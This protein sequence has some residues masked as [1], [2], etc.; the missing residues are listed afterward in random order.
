MHWQPSQE[1]FHLSTSSAEPDAATIIASLAIIGHQLHRNADHAKSL[2]CQHLTEV[3]QGIVHLHITRTAHPTPAPCFV[4]RISMPVHFCEFTYGTLYIVVAS[5]KATFSADAACHLAESCAMLLYTCEM[6][7]LLQQVY[8]HLCSHT[9]AKL[10]PREQDI[11]L[12]LC[13]NKTKDEIATTLSIAPRTLDK[14]KQH[15][16]DK[17]GVHNELAVLLAA[18]TRNLFFPLDKGDE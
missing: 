10:S 17:L 14:H 4:K 13:A 8:L 1:S 18:Y 7:V 6:R 5:G 15:I 3:S 11:L 9:S 2:L 12:L 16:Y